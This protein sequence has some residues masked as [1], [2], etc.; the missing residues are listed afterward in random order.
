VSL[1]RISPVIFLVLVSTAVGARLARPTAAFQGGPPGAS[2]STLVTVPAS[3]RS[4]PF[5]VN[6]N[7]TVPPNFSISV[8]ARIGGARFMAVAPNGD[9]LVSHPGSGRVILVDWN[10]DGSDDFGKVITS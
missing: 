2:V 10:G 1:R 8:Y 9:L 6:R 3:M 4:S 5:N 7:L